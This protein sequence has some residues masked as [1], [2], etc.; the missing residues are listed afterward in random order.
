[1]EKILEGE[2]VTNGQLEYL[3]SAVLITVFYIFYDV[4]HTEVSTSIDVDGDGGNLIRHTNGDRDI[5]LLALILE[6]LID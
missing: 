1:M 6:V 3:V 4:G 5:E 2:L